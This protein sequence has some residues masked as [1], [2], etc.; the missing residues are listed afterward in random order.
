MPVAMHNPH[1]EQARPADRAELLDLLHRVFFNSDPKHPR[2][3]RLY[4]DLFVSEEE[5]LRRHLVVRR[6]GCIVACVGSY[7]IELALG[8]CR[9]RLAGIGQVATAPEARGSGLMTALMQATT[10]RLASEGFALSWLAGRRDGYARFGWEKAGAELHLQLDA[11]SIGQPPTGWRVETRTAAECAGAGAAAFDAAWSLRE[12]HPVRALCSRA[13]WLQRLGRGETVIGVA[14]HADGRAAFALLRREWN[15]LHEWGGDPDGIRALATHFVPQT[16]RLQI[17]LTPSLDPLAATFWSMSVDA[18][19]SM[20][21]LMV[22]DLPALLAAYEPWLEKR[23][24][25]GC[26]ARL[27]MTANGHPAGNAALIG[28][29]VGG[30]PEELTLDR[31]ALARLLFGPV[32]P[33][34]WVGLPSSL[35][36]LG[37]VLP[38][39]LFVPG[40][41]H[42]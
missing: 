8:P 26:A 18:G 41:F 2:F 19:M 3:E 21:N 35:A 36:W 10:E 23:V 38:L 12:A 6:E 7:P 33:S 39:P 30:E 16:G 31:L 25:A 42:V 37:T 9:V 15:M 14:R 13:D 22:L 32:S 1:I 4:P 27:I 20:G 28:K 24:P 5:P 40:T 34:G 17:N 11:H 29:R